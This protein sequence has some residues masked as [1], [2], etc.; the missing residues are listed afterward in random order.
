[1]QTHLKNLNL[2]RVCDVFL[3]TTGSKKR[4]RLDQLL[5]EQGLVSGR[6]RARA[7]VLAREVMV[8]GATVTQPSTLIWSDSKLA[9][10]EKP[11]YVSRGGDKLAHALSQT[12]IEVNGKICL[13]IGVST[14]GFTDCLLQ[15][16][17]VHV[18]AVDVAYGELHTNLRSDG[19]VTIF[20][21]TNA[22][23]LPNFDKVIDLAVMDVSFISARK[24][25]PSLFQAIKPEA[26]V[27]VLVKPQFEAGRSEILKGG[28]VRDSRVH[29]RTVSEVGICAMELGL[30]IEGVVRSPLKGPAG[31]IEFFLRLLK[32]KIEPT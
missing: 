14:G 13:D 31:N 21:R 22:R 16:G 25:L 20:E 12:G 5:V 32:P 27:L 8:D 29:A 9:L 2:L 17:A 28:V 1:M 18:L 11:R 19:R 3:R 24:I 15:N 23:N 7:F 26:E 30:R 6:D 4:V 10:T